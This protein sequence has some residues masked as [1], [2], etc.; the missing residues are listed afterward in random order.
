[1]TKYKV[2]KCLAIGGFSK[3]YKCRVRDTGNFVAIKMLLEEDEQKALRELTRI[4]DYL[5]YRRY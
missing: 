1:L 3:V 5:N 4:A 2:L